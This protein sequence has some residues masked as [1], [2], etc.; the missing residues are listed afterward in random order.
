LE[1]ERKGK[2]TIFRFIQKNKNIVENFQSGYHSS[3][4][5]MVNIVTK[6]Y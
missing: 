5:T 3:K 4:G 1:Q 6:T 2:R